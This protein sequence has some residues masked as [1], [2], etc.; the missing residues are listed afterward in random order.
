[1]SGYASKKEA[2]DVLKHTITSGWNSLAPSTIVENYYIGRLF[3]AT[4]H[5]RGGDYGW[6]QST[7]RPNEYHVVMAEHLRPVARAAII[8]EA[9]ADQMR[10]H[11]VLM[12]R[13]PVPDGLTMRD[14]RDLKHAAFQRWMLARDTDPARKG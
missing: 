6:G 8:A 10:W 5:H 7:D 14:V 2:M 13:E 12:G 11:E 3:D 1:M 9:E 4:F